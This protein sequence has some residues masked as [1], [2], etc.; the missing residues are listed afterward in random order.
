[1]TTPHDDR[2]SLDLSATLDRRLINATGDSVR[3]LV[4]TMRAPQPPRSDA[5]ERLPLNL[6]MVI[7]A[8]GSMQG[9]PLS[10]A[11]AATLDVIQGLDVDDHFS[12]VSFASDVQV[13]ATAVRLDAAGKRM[14]EAAVRPL[15]SRDSTALCDGWLGG[16]EAVATRQAAITHAE[17]HHVMLLSDGHANQGECS[18][19]ALARHA[20]ELRQRGIVTSTVGIGQNYSPTQLQAIAEAGGGRM[21][22]AE[23]P[24]EIARIVLA[25]LKDTLA[26]T[27]E[28]LDVRVD[29]PAGV[30]AELYGT[31][32]LTLHGR[33]CDVLVGS[34][35]GGATRRIVLKLRFP[36]GEQGNRLPIAVRARWNTPGQ[37]DVYECVANSIEPE[38]TTANQCLRQPRDVATATIVAEQWRAF[39]IHEAMK[40]NQDGQFR[41]AGSFVRR[42]LRYFGQYCAG[43]PELETMLEG[44][45]DFEPLL[46]HRYSAET[47]KELML[48][49][50]KTSRYEADHR[51]RAHRSFSDLLAEE[52]RNRGRS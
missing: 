3:H 28:N 27:V 43:V 6:G 26:T 17:R 1:M 48:H 22:D 42:E 10:A 38:F 21:H 20:S 2:D 23:L 44:L 33:R 37:T 5:V 25:E 47:S 40:L 4:I 7:D 14:A 49:S 15:V 45:D 46:V 35:I 36:A 18:P 31:A 39:I 29:L 9:P 19:E 24:E 50:Y 32:P 41:Q 13:H 51:S 34:L 52:R 11:K 30:Q 8:S 12:L 16:C